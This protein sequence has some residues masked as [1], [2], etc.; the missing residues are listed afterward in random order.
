MDLILPRGITGFS[1]PRGRPQ[2][3]PSHFCADCQQVVAL[4]SGRREDLQQVM[5]P[6]LVN[7]ITQLLV[8]PGAEVT[9]LL[10]R[11]YP[12]LG[13]CRVLKPGNCWREFVDPSPRQVIASF[14]SLGRYRLLSWAELNQPVT[15]AMCVELGRAERGQ[16]K[17]W[18]K[19]AG[20]GN[21]RL[22][23]QVY[24]LTVS[25]VLSPRN[26]IR[27]PFMKNPHSIPIGDMNLY[28]GG[29]IESGRENTTCEIDP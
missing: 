27:S 22:A 21:L 28:V 19:L 8:F 11:H 24:S 15:E 12:W 7:F 23:T 10:N 26:T 14:E 5:A 3:D 17:Y 18:S 20:E 13:F 16:L 25:V 29:N 4:L 1:V 2:A 9:A 6:H